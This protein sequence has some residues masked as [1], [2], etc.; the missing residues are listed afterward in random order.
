[1]VIVLQVVVVTP[2]RQCCVHSK[3]VVLSCRC[4]PPAHGAVVYVRT[5]VAVCYWSRLCC[6]DV[7]MVTTVLNG[8]SLD[9]LIYK[10]FISV[11]SIIYL[12][13]CLELS[14]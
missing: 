10:I 9:S 7:A 12:Y 13:V 2:I 4:G 14:N 1:M 6:S 8:T 5:C 3:R 11:I